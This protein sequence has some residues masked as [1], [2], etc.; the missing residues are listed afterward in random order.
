MNLYNANNTSKR[1]STDGVY[2]GMGYM[3]DHY[4]GYCPVTHY[5]TMRTAPSMQ[6]VTGSNYYSLHRNGSGDDFNGL[7][8]GFLLMKTTVHYKRPLD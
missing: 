4:R 7:L 1:V 3:Y 2:F 8:I 5:V 6:T